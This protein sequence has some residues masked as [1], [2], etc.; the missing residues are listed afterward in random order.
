M[1]NQ[2]ILVTGGTGFIGACLVKRL[3]KLGYDTTVFDNNF[4]GSLDRLGDVQDDIKFIEGDIRSAD[5]V[6]NAI[7]GFDTVFHLAFINGTKYFYEKPE[8]VLDVGVK[9][10]LNTL[11]A[12]LAS[13]VSQYILA[14]SSEVYQQPT[15]VPTTESE[16][17]F[18]PDVRNARYSYGGGKIISELLT[19]NYLRN[20]KISHQIFR[21]HNIFGPQMGFEHVIPELIKKIYVAT[22]AFKKDHCGMQIQGTGKETR[23]FCFVE[24]AIDQLIVILKSGQSGEIY[25]IGMQREI[26]IRQLIEDIAAALGVTV[27]ITPGELRK[28]GTSRRCPSIEKIKAL[29]YTGS[30]HYQKGLQETVNWYKDFYMKEVPVGI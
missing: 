27:D 7:Q 5:D 29:G 28:G 1:S 16:R 23:A 10:A 8:L 18:I 6:S 24:D 9:G 20:S 17:I 12:S 22:D 3:V 25:H 30:D 21:P 14:S 13:D 2:K 26:T 15:H 19:L 11:E 4:R